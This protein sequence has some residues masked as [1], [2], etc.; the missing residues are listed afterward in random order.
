MR[1]AL[2]TKII[3]SI[4]AM[5]WALAFHLIN[6]SYTGSIIHHTADDASYLR[7]A[8]NFLHSGTWKDNFTGPSAFVQ[9]PPLMGVQH[10]VFYEISPGTAQFF[11]F[12]LAIL[13][14][15]IAV[16][17]LTGFLFRRFSRISALAT[18]AAYIVLPIFWGFLSYQITEAFAV[19]F[20]TIAICA[21]SDE[22]ATVYRWLTI[23]SMALLF[24]PVLVLL[25]LPFIPRFVRKSTHKISPGTK[26]LSLAL[27]LAVFGWEM[28][29]HTYM[30]NWPD[31]H[32][33]YSAENET[34][35][36]PP[37]HALSD[38]FRLW[39]TKPEN[40]HQISGSLWLGDSTFLEQAQAKAYSDESKCPL[41]AKQLTDL[42][43]RYQSAAI[44]AQ[45]QFGKQAGETPEE[46][47]FAHYCDILRKQTASNYPIQNMLETPARSAIDLFSKSQLNLEI[48]QNYWRGN[49]LTELLRI[50]C[51]TLILAGLIATCV[52]AF[53]ST[54]RV[55]A[56]GAIAYMLYLF[57]F[58]RMNE[59]RYGIVLLPVFLLALTFTANALKSRFGKS[60][61]K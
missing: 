46:K 54:F 38:L 59:D 21:L 15:G 17:I 19:S 42:F 34:M 44:S 4:V 36:R 25:F 50:F 23:C 55:P 10:A 35:F 51:L 12:G 27:L 3:A 30:G 41:T 24:R 47:A 8:E 53:N 22:K 33:I 14:H 60:R 43:R 57:W 11:T 28:R 32:P 61:K 31:P 48:F 40:L 20:V 13:L 56:L 29:K 37:H 6:G 2:R 16:F 1:L 52:C 58:Q 26:L 45:Q 18:L 5:A 9:R 7:P 49:F 39:E